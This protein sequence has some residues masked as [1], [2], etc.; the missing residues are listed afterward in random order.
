MSLSVEF[1]SS[2]N[3]SRLPFRALGEGKDQGEAR[4]LN[5]LMKSHK[6]RQSD[7]MAQVLCLACSAGVLP[8]PVYTQ[9]PSL[10]SHSQDLVFRS[11]QPSEEGCT[12][13]RTFRRRLQAP[14]PTLRSPLEI[15]LKQT[16]LEELA[17]A[18]SPVPTTGGKIYLRVRWHTEHRIIES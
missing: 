18:P 5:V 14:P 13:L 6:R 7:S 15:S 16:G 9:V 11:F 8:M 2:A 12:M 3:I 17:Q 10:A 4:D 1:S